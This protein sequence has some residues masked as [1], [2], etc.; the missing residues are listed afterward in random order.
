MKRARVDLVLFC[1]CACLV[2]VGGVGAT[3]VQNVT[4]ASASAP[5]CARANTGGSGVVTAMEAWG[6]VNP[7]SGD[8]YGLPQEPCPNGGRQRTI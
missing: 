8:C 7:I 1:L 3:G 6:T 4:A 2:V 5:K